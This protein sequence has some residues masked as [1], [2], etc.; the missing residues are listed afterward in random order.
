MGQRLGGIN[1]YEFVDPGI[2]WKAYPPNTEFDIEV[3]RVGVTYD[4]DCGSP[5]IT[6][7]VRVVG[8]RGPLGE[9]LTFPPTQTNM[10]YCSNLDLHE[11]HGACPGRDQEQ[12][13]TSSTWTRRSLPS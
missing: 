10:P 8:A 4:N 1:R 12:L 9:R 3:V 11:A 13:S 2:R 7:Y 5:I 6:Q